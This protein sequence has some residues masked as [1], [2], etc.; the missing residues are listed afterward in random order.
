MSRGTLDTSLKMQLFAYGGLTL[1]ARPSHAFL[2]SH[3]LIML[4]LNPE[5]PKT[6]G[7]GSSQ[8]ARRYYGNLV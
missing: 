4:V 2:L 3:F 7:L 8:F 5:G 6:F 1:Y